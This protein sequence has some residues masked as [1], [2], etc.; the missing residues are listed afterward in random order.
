M[1]ATMVVDEIRRMLR[2][3]RLSQR[4]IAVR[5]SVSRGTVNAVARG[6]RPDYSARRRREDDDFIPPMGIPVR[7]PGCGGLAQMPCLLCYIQKLQKK[8]C[9]TASR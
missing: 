6:K 1:I 9:R 2:E 5:L 4:K 7:C 8:N 3:G